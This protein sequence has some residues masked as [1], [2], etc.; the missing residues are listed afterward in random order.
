MKLCCIAL[1]TQA[2]SRTQKALRTATVFGQGGKNATRSA[3]DGIRIR[4]DQ[5]YCCHLRSSAPAAWQ[6]TSR[7]KRCSCHE[8]FQSQYVMRFAQSGR[9]WRD[10]AATFAALS[11]KAQTETHVRELRHRSSQ[12]VLGSFEAPQLS[13]SESCIWFQ[14]AY[15]HALIKILFL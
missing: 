9:S 5:V 15:S 4:G 1:F 11:Q 7:S 12:P 14:S 13:T 3:G 10:H 6:T 8:S 2:A